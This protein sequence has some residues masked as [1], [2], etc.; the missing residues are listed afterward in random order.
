MFERLY[1]YRL[2]LFR[3]GF[4]FPGLSLW[5]R[6]T[7]SP[8]NGLDRQ[9]TFKIIVCIPLVLISQEH[10]GPGTLGRFQSMS[11]NMWPGSSNVEVLL[12]YVV[13]LHPLVQDAQQLILVLN[14]LIWGQLHRTMAQSLGGVPFEHA[15]FTL[16]VVLRQSFRTER[17]FLSVV[18]LIFLANL[19]LCLSVVTTLDLLFAQRCQFTKL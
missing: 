7:S 11:T 13:H 12:A 19:S 5:A 18:R 17:L 16:Q 8:A 14:L 1:L 9:R 6:E 3:L 10:V 4:R 2:S 15:K